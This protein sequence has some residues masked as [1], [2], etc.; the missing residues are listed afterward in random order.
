MAN[1]QDLELRH[2]SALRAVAQEGSFG[3]AAARLGFS[4]SAISQQISGLER[5]L[6]EPVFD[7]PGG[8]RRPE[9]TPAGRMLLR[10]AESILDRV[11]LVQDELD[12]LRSGTTGRL[13]VGTFQSV[14]VKLLPAIVGRLRI[15]AP[16]IDIRLVET[17]LDPVL[18]DGLLKDEMD[19]AFMVGPINDDRIEF[20]ELRRDPFVVVLPG[21]QSDAPDPYPTQR[22]D[23]VAMVGEQLCSCQLLIEQGLQQLGVSPTYVFRSNDNSAVQ[24]MVRAG[25]GAAVMPL[26][27]VESTDPEIAVRFLDPPLEPRTIGLAVLRGRTRAPATNRFIEL[28]VE[29]CRAMSDSVSA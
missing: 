2:L 15:E 29:S 11:A 7:R 25:M 28:A 4:Q 17:D 18:I 9:L 26:L 5:A 20:I 1:L 23:S 19:I 3:R 10:H 8:P 14:S 27:A 12:A 16:D 22:L 6:G 21:D 24:A 13:V